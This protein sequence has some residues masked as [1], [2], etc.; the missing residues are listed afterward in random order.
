M[1]FLVVS[2][3]GLEMRNGRWT[4]LYIPI[5]Q[6]FRFAETRLPGGPCLTCVHNTGSIGI[7]H[8]KH[9]IRQLR[10]SRRTFSRLFLSAVSDWIKTRTKVR[11]PFAATPNRF[12]PIEIGIFPFSDAFAELHIDQYS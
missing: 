8:W 4:Y 7:L 6:L 2:T 1:R 5:F 9:E 11:I 10:F 3:A 12:S